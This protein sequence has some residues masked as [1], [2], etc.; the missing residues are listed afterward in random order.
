[1]R[2]FFAGDMKALQ[3]HIRNLKGQL[4]VARSL[5]PEADP[6]LEIARTGSTP[7]KIKLCNSAFEQM[8][9]ILGDLSMLA[10]SAEGNP[11]LLQVIHSKP[12]MQQVKDDINDTL[13][14]T[15]Q[16]L[17]SVLAHKS[18][19]AVQE[20]CVLDLMETSGLQQLDGAK[21]LVEQLNASPKELQLEGLEPGAFS[22][23]V[24]ALENAAR[25]LDTI[26]QLCLKERI[27]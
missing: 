22:L 5:A 14:K 26:A 3:E 19:E 13:E 21:E 7:F 10:L 24:R 15:L 23:V 9:L 11:M 6:A 17:I 8:K 16:T 2:L 18:D 20:K 12:A 4:A 25:H 1:M 27:Y